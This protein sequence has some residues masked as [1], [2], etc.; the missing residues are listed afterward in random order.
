MWQ[1]YF[2]LPFEVIYSKV[3][4]K[5]FHMVFDFMNLYFNFENKLNLSENNQQI[6]LDCING[7]YKLKNKE[8]NFIFDSEKG[9]ILLNNCP[10]IILRGWGYL[11][12]SRGCKLHPDKAF[13]VQNSLG[14]YII[15]KLNEK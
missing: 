1:E 11:T 7:N 12:G 8:N 5:D 9:L 10:I 6:L 2:K 3:F 13:E 15:S 14:E 4:D